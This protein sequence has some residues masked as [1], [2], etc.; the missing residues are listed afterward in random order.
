MANR[1]ESEPCEG[2]CRIVRL[3]T[4][5]RDVE[6]P[7]EHNGMKVVSIGPR[8]L[9]GSL[10]ADGRRVRIPATV[11]DMDPDALGGVIGI[12]EVDYGGDISIF[13]GFG[14]VTESDCT[15]RCLEGDGR[16]EFGFLSG[17]PMSFPAF[18]EAV[19]SMSIRLT[20]EIASKRLRDPVGLTEEARAGYVK[21]LSRVLMPRAEQAVTRSDT[22]SLSEILSTGLVDDGMLRS[23]LERSL[24][25]GK[26]SV[27]SMLMS[28]IRARRLK[29]G[30]NSRE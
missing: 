28:E 27:T 5:D 29:E 10:P 15:L 8:V 22:S 9:V 6:I 1:M 11:T 17:H 24:R 26:T 20:P 23:L 14:V 30:Q 12:S 16:F 18:D 25:S 7:P 19:L 3:V 13:N 4:T 21:V 2:G